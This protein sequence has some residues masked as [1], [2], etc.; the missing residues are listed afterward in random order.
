MMH[1]MTMTSNESII[2][3]RWEDEANCLTVDPDLFFPERGASPED[4]KAVCAGCIVRWE[5]LEA[6][7]ARR[8]Q[9]GIWGGLTAPER[10]RILDGRTRLRPI[11]EPA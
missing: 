11:P 1:G 6:S 2:L 9:H 10:R 3:G 8:E 5:C 7:L 4:A